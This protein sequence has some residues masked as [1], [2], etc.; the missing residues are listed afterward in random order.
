MSDPTPPAADPT[1]DQPNDDDLRD[2]LAKRAHAR[3]NRTT[4]VLLALIAVG[5][6]FALGACT[7][8]VMGSLTEGV[9]APPPP[10]ASTQA[11]RPPADGEPADS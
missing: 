6:G 2:M 4:W 7:Q 10:S 3:P 5:I 9:D 8:R 1:S 11:D